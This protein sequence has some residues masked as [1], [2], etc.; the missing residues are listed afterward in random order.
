[1]SKVSQQV[2]QSMFNHLVASYTPEE[3]REILVQKYPDVD[4]ND[5]VV[6]A[7]K[8]G[9]TTVEMGKVKST[10]ESSNGDLMK[11]VK[12]KTAKPKKVAADKGPKAE[13][14]VD[15][16]RKLYADSADKSRGAMIAIFQANLGMS[17]AAASTYYYNIKG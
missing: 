7:T 2:I 6:D 14:K 10:P 11:A 1:M 12:V 8:Y 16:A 17:K 4:A 5:L 3:A 13:S 9:V 15:L